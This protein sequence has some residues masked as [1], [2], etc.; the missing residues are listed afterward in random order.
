MSCE[1]VEVYFWYVCLSREKLC[2]NCSNTIY[3][4]YR[5]CDTDFSK[6]F[7]Q[8]ITPTAISHPN[9]SS[10]LKRCVQ[11]LSNLTLNTNIIISLAYESGGIVIM[12]K[13]KFADK[14]NSFLEDTDTYEISNL[15]T[16][17]QHIIPFN[18]LFKKLIN[19]QKIWTSVIEHHPSI[20]TL[21]GLPK[22]HKPRYPLRPIISSIGRATHKI[23]RAIAEIL[24]PPTRH[25]Q[26]LTHQKLWRL[27]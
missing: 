14:I 8:G 3:N 23:A 26:P 9:K 2:L 17:S 5:N 12:H 27:S 18:K 1:K 16:I 22:I 7:I 15:T 25:N 24:I 13:Q 19:N 4:N 20:P 11:A 6:G 10:L 21:Y